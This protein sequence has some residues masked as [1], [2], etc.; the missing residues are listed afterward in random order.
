MSQYDA[1]D[2]ATKLF[3]T[4]FADGGITESLCGATKAFRHTIK[5]ILHQY[6]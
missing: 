5:Q 2:F 1:T 6:Q 4:T 3:L